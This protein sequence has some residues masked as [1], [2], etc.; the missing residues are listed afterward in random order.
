MCKSLGIGRCIGAHNAQSGQL[1]I[2]HPTPRGEGALVTEA[3]LL[4]ILLLLLCL[5]LLLLLHRL[6]LLLLHLI[7]LLQLQLLRD[8]PAPL[9]FPDSSFLC[10]HKINGYSII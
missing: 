3:L 10:S 4:L 8:L 1:T 6:L 5:I 7:L 9:N 2:S